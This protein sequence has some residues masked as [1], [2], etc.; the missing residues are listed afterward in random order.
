MF[1][2]AVLTQELKFQYQPEQLNVQF[3]C[4][5]SEGTKWKWRQTILASV[6]ILKTDDNTLLRLPGYRS[7]H[8]IMVNLETKAYD[9]FINSVLYIPQYILHRQSKYSK[10]LFSS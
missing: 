10:T 9:G 4:K 7:M 1:H 6:K 2:F 5:T 3:E 8:L